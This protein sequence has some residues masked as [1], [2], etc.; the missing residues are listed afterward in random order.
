MADVKCRDCA[1]RGRYPLD[2]CS[3]QE[4][5]PFIDPDDTCGDADPATRVRPEDACPE[6]G[7]DREDWLEWSNDSAIR[8]RSC[9]HDYV[10]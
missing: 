9:G 2:Y 3:K 7:E 6:C 4:G 1:W 10:P 5:T 8:C